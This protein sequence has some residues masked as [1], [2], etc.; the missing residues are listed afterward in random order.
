MDKQS[1]IALAHEYSKLVIQHFPVE[2]ILLYGSFVNGTAGPY[3]DIDIAVI[4]EEL[5]GDYLE[6]QSELYRLRRSVDLRI[7][8]IL[9]VGWQDDSGFLQEIK[10][11]GK[12]VY[13]SETATH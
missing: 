7:E 5:E 6:K 13:S 11:T 9:F 12:I 3:S 2:Q 4:V 1:V 8:P 10:A